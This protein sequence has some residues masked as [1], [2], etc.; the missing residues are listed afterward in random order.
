[1]G[2]GGFGGQFGLEILILAAQD[3]SAL[4]VRSADI[5][6]LGDSICLNKNRISRSSIL[7]LSPSNCVL[8]IADTSG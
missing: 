8:A 6:L 4:R 3:P 7:K 5:K 1:M 2:R